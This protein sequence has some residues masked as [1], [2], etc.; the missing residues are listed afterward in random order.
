MP[1]LSPESSSAVN[2]QYI[3]LVFGSIVGALRR[4]TIG[5]KFTEKV[6]RDG[7]VILARRGEGEIKIDRGSEEGRGREG[8]E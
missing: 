2:I 6:L 4:Y 8:P 3:P 7:C 1:S 5:T